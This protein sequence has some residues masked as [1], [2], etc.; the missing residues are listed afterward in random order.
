MIEDIINETVS[1][2]IE[3]AMSK[4]FNR[5][6]DYLK[7]SINRIEQS[8][9]LQTYSVLEAS[10]ITGIGYTKLYNA[11]NNGL[12]PHFLDGKKKRIRHTDLNQWIENEKQKKENRPC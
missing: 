12:L 1:K 8:I 5:V 10:R 7:D 4:A 9:N 6:P 11:V 3:A 2:S